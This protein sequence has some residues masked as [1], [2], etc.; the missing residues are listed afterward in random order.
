MGLNRR[1]AGATALVVVIGV[2][3]WAYFT[4]QG[5]PLV[6]GPRVLAVLAF[7]LGV[8]A[9]AIS[10]RSIHKKLADLTMAERLVRLRAPGGFLLMLWAAVTGDE[11]VLGLLISLIGVVWLG[12]TIQH[13]FGKRSAT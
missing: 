8:M 11:V 10:S 7:V 6:S 13:A 9:S 4:A 2:L 12:S 5:W 3:A 1:D